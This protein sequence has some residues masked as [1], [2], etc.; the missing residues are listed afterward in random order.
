M[1]HIREAA[2]G[3]R[4]L[5]EIGERPVEEKISELTD[6]ELRPLRPEELSE[7]SKLVPDWSFKA[8]VKNG[9]TRI[10][11]E[12]NLFGGEEGNENAKRAVGNTQELLYELYDSEIELESIRGRSAGPDKVV[13]FLP[14]DTPVTAKTIREINTVDRQLAVHNVFGQT[15]Y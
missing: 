5:R 7:L 14:D 10:Q 13:A 1:T 3:N 9:R 15:D 6:P 11:I 8:S 12:R 4:V 2:P